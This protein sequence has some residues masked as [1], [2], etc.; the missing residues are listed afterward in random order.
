T[1]ETLTSGE[2]PLFT[3]LFTSLNGVLSRLTGAPLIVFYHA[4]RLLF[5]ALALLWFHA[6]CAQL[7]EDRRT[8]L[9]AVALAAFSGGWGW[10]ARLWP[11]PSLQNFFTD[12][13]GGANAMPE[14]YTFLSAFIFPLFIASIALLALIYALVLHAQ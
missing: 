3:N 8:R 9:L 4:L 1:H 13:P 5:A 12:W 7:T 10:L 14:A 6:L 11:V 2:R